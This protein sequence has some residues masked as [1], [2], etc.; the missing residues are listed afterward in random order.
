MKTQLGGFLAIFLLGVTIT[1]SAQ[2][3]YR[4]ERTF[5]PATV[6]TVEGE[7]TEVVN[8]EA[9][10]GNFAGV[11]LLVKLENEEVPVH[12]GPAWFIS[13][14]E[15]FN[16]GETIEITGSRVTYEGK[17]AMIAVAIRRGDMTLKLRDDNGFP[18]W[19][20][21]HKNRMGGRMN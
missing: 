10:R 1:L 18:Y 4:Y 20:A 13:K 3:G 12:L 17:P 16:K 19:R 14:Q 11:H 15:P 21:W 2:P 9:K 7:I 8:T 6:Q 5:D